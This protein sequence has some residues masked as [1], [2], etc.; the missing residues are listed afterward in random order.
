MSLTARASVAS[1]FT[2]PVEWGLANAAGAGI[3]R[4]AMMHADRRFRKSGRVRCGLRVIDGN[5]PGLS[6]RW[7]VGVASF[8]V[9]RLEFLRRWWRVLGECPPIEVIAVHGPS[10]APSGD[11][12]LKLPGSIVQIQTPTATLEWALHV[13]YQ[14][15]AVAQLKVA[16]WVPPVGA[17]GEELAGGVMPSALDV[18]AHPGRGRGVSD[19]VRAQSGFHGRACAGSL[20][21]RYASSRSPALTAASAALISSR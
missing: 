4:V 9:R 17:A 6:G 5:Q 13:R 16:Q 21:N 11:E 1:D 2:D 12:I 15:A 7:R 3:G 10:R 8:S 14:S 18:E 20:E 19:L